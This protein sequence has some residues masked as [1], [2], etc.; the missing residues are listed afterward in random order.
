[1]NKRKLRLKYV[2]QLAFGRSQCD[3]MA[4]LLFQYL[5]IHNNEDLPNR[6]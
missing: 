6:I 5:A 4:I 1:M 3:Q 2:Q